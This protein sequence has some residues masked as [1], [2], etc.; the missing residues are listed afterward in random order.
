VC[1]S[2]GHVEKALQACLYI[3]CCGISLPLVPYAIIFF[4]NEGS[5]KHT[6]ENRGVPEPVDEGD[7]QMEYIYN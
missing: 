6:E 3:N 5:R 7:I 1:R 4:S 2:E